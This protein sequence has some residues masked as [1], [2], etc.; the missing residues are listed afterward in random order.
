MVPTT[1]ASP[2]CQAWLKSKGCQ[3]CDSRLDLG[4]IQGVYLIWAGIKPEVGAGSDP[5]CLGGRA[6][7]KDTRETVDQDTRSGSQSALHTHGS[8]SAESSNMD[9]KYLGRKFQKAKKKKKKNTKLELAGPQATVYIAFIL[10][11]Q[12]VTLYEVL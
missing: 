3:A 5:T 12:L 4:R 10:Y 9:Q 2:A 11:L 7:N 8:A 1:Q 6:G